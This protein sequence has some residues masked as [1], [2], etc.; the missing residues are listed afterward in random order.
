[1]K[2]W[3]DLPDRL[4]RVRPHRG[5]S[6]ARPVVQL[7]TAVA[8]LHD[9]AAE[10][11]DRL[12]RELAAAAL[13]VQRGVATRVVVANEPGTADLDEISLLADTFA[14]T[15]ESVIRVGGGAFDFV[16]HARGD[17]RG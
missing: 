6:A 14:V 5:R 12:L 13:L 1:M 17:D 9:P 15:V 3:M 4:L 10:A 16:V 11:D 7:A 2:L 8:P